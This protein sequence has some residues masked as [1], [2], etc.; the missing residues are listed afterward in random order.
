MLR[1]GL[2][3]DEVYVTNDTGYA[4]Q[5]EHKGNQ[6]GFSLVA[7]ASTKESEVIHTQHKQYSQKFKFI[8]ACGV[9]LEIVFVV[10]KHQSYGSPKED[11]SFLKFDEDLKRQE[12][13]LEVFQN[14][15]K[16]Q[17]LFQ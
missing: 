6:R 5:N 2:E 16:L 14:A 10:E 12:A 4:Q 15:N 13:N 3:N 7:L 11:K 1:V 17:G 9:I 8:V